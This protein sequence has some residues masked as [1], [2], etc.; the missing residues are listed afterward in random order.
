MSRQ[1]RRGLLGHN[2]T[3]FLLLISSL[4]DSFHHSFEMYTEAEKDREKKQ[5][6]A[7]ARKRGSCLPLSFSSSFLFVRPCCK[8]LTETQLFISV[9]F[10][11]P[12]RSLTPPSPFP[13]QI[14]GG[15]RKS[16]GHKLHLPFLRSFPFSS[17]FFRKEEEG[18]FPPFDILLSLLVSFVPSTIV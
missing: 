8:V 13:T 18:A 3:L 2:K 6:K 17:F 16:R 14:T 10:F 9:L 11:L 5:S 7:I 15:A 12:L 4:S 1:W